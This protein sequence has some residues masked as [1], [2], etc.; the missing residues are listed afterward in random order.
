MKKAA[1][2]LVLI[3]AAIPLLAADLTGVW[4]AA[5]VLD[6]GSGVATFTFK[7]T[8]DTLTGTYM[9]TFGEAK[10][11]GTVKG[12]DVEWS[13]DAPDAGKATYNGTVSGGNK[14][15]GTVVYGALGKGTFT[16]ERK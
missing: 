13:F 11:T 2:L 16:A 4:T 10:V 14:I 12:D 15:S 9:G 5:V 8:G 6:A 1:T 3:L 7:Q